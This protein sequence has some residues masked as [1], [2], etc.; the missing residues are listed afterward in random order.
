MKHPKDSTIGGVARAAGVNVETVRYYQRVGL[1]PVPQR[2]HGGFREYA[3]DAPDPEGPDCP[4]R[5]G[6]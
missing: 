4:L 1:V 5:H 2:R 6:R 3:P